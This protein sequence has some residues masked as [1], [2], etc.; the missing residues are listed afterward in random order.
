MIACTVKRLLKG[1]ILIPIRI[2]CIV[3]NILDPPH[4]HYRIQCAIGRLT[5][6]NMRVIKRT[7]TLPL[8]VIH[9]MVSSILRVPMYLEGLSMSDHRMACNA[10]RTLKFFTPLNDVLKAIQA[11]LDWLLGFFYPPKPVIPSHPTP[12]VEETPQPPDSGS[13]LEEPT[14][15]TP[16]PELEKE[17]ELTENPTPS[18]EPFVEEEVKEFCDDSKVIREIEDE[19]TFCEETLRELEA[20]TDKLAAI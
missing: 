20:L 10:E 6:F 11:F 7:I 9:W 12:E 14:S 2:L 3:Y 8:I 15:P 18:A 17:T 1:F 4:P 19:L 13:E 16:Q 5:R